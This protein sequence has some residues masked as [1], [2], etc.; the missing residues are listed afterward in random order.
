MKEII[1][2][3]V[4]KFLWQKFRELRIARDVKRYPRRVVEH[5]YYGHRLKVL[6]ADSVGE[7]WYDHD[8]EKLYEIDLLCQSRLR[9]GATVFDLGSHQ[10]VVAMIMAK[11]VSESGRVVAV[12]G[13]KHNCDVASDNLRHNG[14]EN[15]LVHHAVI[16]DKDGSIRFFDG[17]NGSVA[18]EGVGQMV[19]AI[20]ID[21]LANKYGRPDVVFVDVEGFE[22]KVLEGASQTLASNADWFLE[23]HVGCG[24]E[25]Y[26][27]S[28]SKVLSHFPDHEYR[29]FI[30][31]LDT[32]QLPQ[33]LDSL[34]PILNQRFAFVALS[35]RNL[36][37]NV[38]II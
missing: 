7:G 1:R 20:T 23:V 25:K 14:I 15:V 27:G 33:P 18:S 3:I 36:C 17:L 4:P 29:C 34:S 31:N 21:S 19:E 22:L 26:G 5:V 6:I 12:E 28:V 24:L 11:A 35:I 2:R 8:W 30:W 16:A 10:G 38:G 37:E 32:E 13:M 9:P